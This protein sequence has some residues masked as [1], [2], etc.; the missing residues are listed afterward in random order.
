MKTVSMIV[1]ITSVVLL[2]MSLAHAAT[3]EVA[4]TDELTEEANALAEAALEEKKEVSKFSPGM[5]IPVDG[6]SEKAFDQS[7]ETIKSEA[8]EAEYTSLLGAVGYLVVYDLGA[9][10]DRAKV[11]KN[12]DGMT[13]E[14]ILGLVDWD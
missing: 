11:A 14:E 12:L 6:S 4:K 2:S 5:Q 9:R 13:G 1:G 8:T 3:T 7:L 10:R